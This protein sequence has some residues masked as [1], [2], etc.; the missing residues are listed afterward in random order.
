MENPRILVVDDSHSA[1]GLYKKLLQEFNSDT[2]LASDGEEA[3]HKTL[4]N[5]YDLIITDIDMPRM[6]GI[7]L[8]QILRSNPATCATPIII[9]SAFSSESD[10]ERGFK[11]GASAYL[12]KK[13]V[14]QLLTRTVGEVLWKN[15]HI[16]QRKILLVDD[17]RSILTMVEEGLHEN[18]FHTSSALNGKLALEL[19][20]TSQPDLILSDINMPFMDGFD[21]C[22][23]VKADPK[24]ASIPFVVMSTRAEKVHMKRMIQYGA[25][26][27]LVKPFNINQMVLLIEKI[28][29]DHFLMLLKEE[30]LDRER[31]MVEDITRQYQ[32]EQQ[33]HHAKKLES[34]GQL[35]AGIA[36]EINTPMQFISDN[37]KFLETAFADLLEV[38]RHYDALFSRLKTGGVDPE[39]IRQLEDVIQDSDLEFLEEEIP[40]AISGS[41]EGI[42][43]VTEIVRAMK[44]FSHPAGNALVP[45]DINKAI[46]CTVAVSR[47]EW[48]YVANLE[49]CLDPSPPQVPCYPGPLNQVLLNIIVNAAH[50]IEQRLGPSPVEKGFIRISTRSVDDGFEISI[51]D[52]GVG[53][54]ESHLSR[55]FDPF[56]TTKPV[57]KGTGQGLSIAYSVVVDQHKG[58]LKVESE[59]GRGATFIIQLPLSRERG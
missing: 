59:E 10:I 42:A 34:I 39:A 56:F 1:L 40:G 21:L 57:G 9:A 3:V 23:A 54:P 17:S 25:A 5:P 38:L 49:T 7:E 20:T 26:A 8:C 28:L 6:D 46:D 37:T 29:F 43:R 12:T 50:A 33:S 11:A 53:I 35:A 51:Q 41:L 36:H 45:V 52:S 31:E 15:R 55:I 44:D 4:E 30:R 32:V 27:Y 16:R 24:L 48:K 58:K 2:H 19:L 18:G 22:K 14:P 13:E 47:N